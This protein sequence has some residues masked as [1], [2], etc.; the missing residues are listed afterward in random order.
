METEVEAA[1]RRNPVAT[2]VRLILHWLIKTPLLVVLGIRGLL[3]HRPI[4]YA[5]VV[6]L[7]AGAFGWQT[8]GSLLGGIRTNA[9]TPST[10]PT[11]MTADGD[12][13]LGAAS[14]LPPSPVVERYIQALADYDANTMW[15]LLGEDLQSFMQENS[16]GLALEQLQLGLDNLRERGGRYI[17]GTYVGGTLMEDGQSVYFYVLKIDT[18]VGEL[19]MPYTYTVGV[20]GKLAGIDQE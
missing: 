12:V 20:D 14:S 16:G 11:Q 10:Q 1:S 19:E 18:P 5:L 9:L 4:R 8:Y 6:L 17:G 2:L 15:T 13:S 3:K 7:I